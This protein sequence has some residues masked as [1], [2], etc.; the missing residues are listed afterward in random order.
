MKTGKLFL[1]LCLGFLC[2]CNQPS[3]NEEVVNESSE[4]V[5]KDWVSIEANELKNPYDICKNAMALSVA[6]QDEHN[7]MAIGWAGFGSFLNKPTV[8]V[9]VSKDRYTHELIEKSQYFTISCFD[10]AHT[11]N[12]M[13][14][15]SNSG[16]DDKNKIESAGLSY[17]LTELG[18]IC[19]NESELCIECKIIYKAD[20]NENAL[21]ADAAKFYEEH[22]MGIHTMYIGEIVNIWKK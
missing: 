15:G 12:L 6:S 11:S 14:L 20:L 18:N 13:Y 8:T 7:A 17:K 2:A 9:Y 5:Q 10:E 16:R 22:P 1:A 4:D 21:D 19:I 3:T